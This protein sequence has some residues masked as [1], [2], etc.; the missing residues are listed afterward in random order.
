MERFNLRQLI[1]MGIKEQIMLKSQTGVQ[2][3]KTWMIIWISTEL[4][5]VYY[6]KCQIFK[7]SLGYYELKQQKPQYEEKC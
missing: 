5:E 3:W 7:Q 4:G 1:D 2:L 6:R